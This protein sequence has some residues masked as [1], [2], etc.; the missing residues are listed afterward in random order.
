MSEPVELVSNG[1][2]KNARYHVV[3]AENV[4][5]YDESNCGH[6]FVTS[7]C[8]VIPWPESSDLENSL[9]GIR[10]C[11]KCYDTLTLG[12][13]ARLAGVGCKLPKVKVA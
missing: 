2:Y 8:K 10:I 3:V 12:Q 7:Q 9:V 13:K 1:T 4:H 5:K 6:L 11:E